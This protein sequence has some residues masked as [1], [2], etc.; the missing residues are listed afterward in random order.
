[1]NFYLQSM[2]EALK[3]TN[4][5]EIGLTSSESERRLETNGKNKLDEGEKISLLSRFVSQLKDPMII[6]L[7]V[8]AIVSGITAAYANESFVDVFIIITVVIINAVL[9]VFQESKA[10]KAI[11]ALQEMA[12][13]TSKV[14]RDGNQRLI[15]S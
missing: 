7:I 5:S 2:E 12:A 6:I 14:L 3:K 8:A 13:S 11:E 9:G 15:R 1:M 4:S 10:E